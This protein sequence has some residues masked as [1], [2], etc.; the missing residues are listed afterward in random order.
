MKR[1]GTH[2]YG[3]NGSSRRK[4]SLMHDNET[5]EVD[6][7][8]YSNMATGVNTTTISAKNAALRQD[9]THAQR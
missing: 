8:Y 2:N 6:C 4:I 5:R 7:N 3:K 1:V 9:A